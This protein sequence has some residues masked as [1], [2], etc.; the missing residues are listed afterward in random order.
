MLSKANVRGALAGLGLAG[1]L[2]LL[3]SSCHQAIMTAPPGSTIEVIANPD[4][5]PAFGGVS[6]I[7]AVVYDG[8]GQPVSD[9]TVVQ[10]FTNL[11]RVDEQG[12]TNDGVAKVNLVADGR[13]GKATVTGLIGGGVIPTPSGTGSATPT[14][15]PSTNSAPGALAG[16]ATTADAGTAASGASAA[17][18]A[19]ASDSVDVTIG[20]ALPR[21]VLLSA[22]PRNISPS[23]PRYTTLTATVFGDSGNPIANIPVVFSILTRSDSDFSESLESGGRPV[24]TDTNGQARDRLFTSIPRDARAQSVEVE[25]LVVVGSDQLTSN[26]V[27]VGI[28]Y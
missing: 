4:F 27:I 5:I 28:N 11:G 10:F 26:S 13:S 7:T 20:T 18:T 23:A 8:T 12:R 6:V 1:G 14:A 9:G 19:S 2:V 16:G 15:T 21:S 3:G 25:A 17:S 22:E 24:F